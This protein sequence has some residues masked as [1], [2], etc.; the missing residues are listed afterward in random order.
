[1]VN[2]AMPDGLWGRPES[3]ARSATQP[4]RLALA[5]GGPLGRISWPDPRHSGW[6][7]KCGQSRP[8]PDRDLTLT[9]RHCPT[10]PSPNTRSSKPGA[11]SVAGSRPLSMKATAHGHAR[12]LHIQSCTASKLK[13]VTVW[14]F[15]GK[16]WWPLFK[17][18]RS[19]LKMSSRH[20]Q[21]LRSPCHLSQHRVSVTGWDPSRGVDH[22][23]IALVQTHEQTDSEAALCLAGNHRDRHRA[24]LLLITGPQAAQQ[25]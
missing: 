11:A 25:E 12:H 5:A 14:P 24:T 23:K 2:P 8:G 19:G 6:H 18:D 16:V 9:R 10:L 22:R 13:R 4:R 3:Q 21:A 7:G 15:P 20:A 17:T 1:M